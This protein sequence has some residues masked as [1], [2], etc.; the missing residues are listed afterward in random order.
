MRIQSE[1]ERRAAERTLKEVMR[2]LEEALRLSRELEE[3]REC[4]RPMAGTRG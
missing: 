2:K 1:E 4:D 3:H